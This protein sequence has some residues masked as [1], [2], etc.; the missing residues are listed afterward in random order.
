MLLKIHFDTES[1][2]GTETKIKN[3]MQ[4]MLLQRVYQL[5]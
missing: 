4:L 3:L 2:G 1:R 5:V